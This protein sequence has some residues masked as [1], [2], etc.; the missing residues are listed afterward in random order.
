MVRL[1]TPNGFSRTL[2]LKS[3]FENKNIRSAFRGCFIRVARSID[4]V[5]ADLGENPR[6]VN[7]RAS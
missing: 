3:I 1:V 4:L 2:F 6:G 5:F 7:N